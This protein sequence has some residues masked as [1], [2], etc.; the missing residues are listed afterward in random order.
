MLWDFL[1]AASRASRIFSPLEER[2]LQQQLASRVED[3]E[4]QIGHRH[5][6]HQFFADLLSSQALLQRAE[7]KGA[8]GSGD[9]LFGDA[10]SAAGGT[11][12]GQPA[13]R[14]RYIFVAPGHDFA[15]ENHVV[16]QTGQRVRQF[17]EGFGDLVAG[18]REDSHFAAGT[19][20][21]G[22]DAVVFV[23]YQGVFEIAESFLRATRPGWPA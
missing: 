16:R 14:R 19:V 21:L 5:L 11:P 4:D 18:A 6:L 15:V 22:A 20:R 13:G 3:I 9:L 7:R 1:G 10:F 23:F 2:T 17:G 8:A 12:A